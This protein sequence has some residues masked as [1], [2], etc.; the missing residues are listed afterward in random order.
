MGGM[1]KMLNPYTGIGKHLPVYICICR[2]IYA[3]ES[4][5]EIFA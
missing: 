5:D 3:H 1:G 4:V 2:Q